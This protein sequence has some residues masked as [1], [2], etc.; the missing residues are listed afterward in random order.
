MCPGYKPISNLG[1]LDLTV[2]MDFQLYATPSQE[3][4]RLD[5]A[6]DKGDELCSLHDF[7]ESPSE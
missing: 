3:R 4:P 1:P 2:P 6:S 5:R 7:A